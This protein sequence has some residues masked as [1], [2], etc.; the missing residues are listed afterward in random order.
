MD[1]LAAAVGLAPRIAAAGDAIE[2]ERRL[3]PALVAALAEG[4]IFRMLVPRSVGGGEAEP[5]TFAQVVETIGAADG[6]TAW[7]VSQGAVSATIAAFL[8]PDVAR[9]IFGQPGAIM[10]QGVAQR[11]RAIAVPGGFRVTGEWSF[12]SGCR[13]ATWLN[14]V[15]PVYLEDGTPR[16]LAD[17]AH[18]GRAMLFPAAEAEIRDTWKVSGLRG[19]GS[20]TYA[21][22]ALFIPE[23]RTVPQPRDGHRREPGPL[24]S[25]ST[26]LLF[27]T[28]FASVA[29]GIARGALDAYEALAGAKQPRAHAT[30]LRESPLEQARVARAEATLRSARAFLHES[31]AAAWETA[32]RGDELPV[33]QKVLLR[34]AA[35]SAIRQAGEV[36]DTAYHAA[37]ATAVFESNPFERRFRDANAVTQQFQGSEVHFPAT[38]RYFLG[39]EPT[40]TSF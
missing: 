34:L 24:Y 38:G 22:E 14:A 17:G 26:G 28:G 18:E 10:A 33:E 13:H 12:G 1:V 2:R 23:E 35:T 40:A 30:V 15:S 11:P 9:E 37:G 36:T 6:S 5:A 27:A 20:D 39:L 3:P 32:A 7:C 31:I 21:I 19:T 29:L 8:P 25:F 4:G 16:R